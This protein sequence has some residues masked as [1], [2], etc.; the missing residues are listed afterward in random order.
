MGKREYKTQKIGLGEIVVTVPLGPNGKHGE[1]ILDKSD[2]DS[3]LT[4]GVSTNW[5][6]TKGYVTASGKSSNNHVLIARVLTGASHGERVRFLDGNK[7][8]LRRHNLK[9]VKGQGSKTDA[10]YV[11]GI[12]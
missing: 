5:T 12:L 6:V 8:N 7:L 1:C 3:L 10:L 2:M 11:G 4:M 9:L